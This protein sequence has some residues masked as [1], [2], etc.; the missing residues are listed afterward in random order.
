MK[1]LTMRI[2][3]SIHKLENNMTFKDLRANG[4]L[5]NNFGEKFHEGYVR[6]LQ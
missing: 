1:F 3:K 5:V 6:A 4:I 2:K